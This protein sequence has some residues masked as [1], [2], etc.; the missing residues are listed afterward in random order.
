MRGVNITPPDLSTCQFQTQRS[1][2]ELTGF[3]CTANSRVNANGN[4]VYDVIEPNSLRRAIV[5]WDDYSEKV[6]LKEQRYE[7]NWQVN[8]ESDIYIELPQGS[9]AFRRP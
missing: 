7:G 1:S 8:Q 5:L 3:Q 2:N 4:T 9:I 6:L